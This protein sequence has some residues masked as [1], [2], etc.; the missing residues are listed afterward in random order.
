MEKWLKFDLKT[1]Q[2]NELTIK[3][4]ESLIVLNAIFDTTFYERSC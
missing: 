1:L 4:L 2:D 3:T